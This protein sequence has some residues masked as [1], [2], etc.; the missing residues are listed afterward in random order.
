MYDFLHTSPLTLLILTMEGN[1]K[2]I[3]TI[4]MAIA[5]AIS[6]GTMG[7]PHAAI[8]AT[9][10]KNGDCKAISIPVT[11]SATDTEQLSVSATFCTPTVWQLSEKTIDIM[12]SGATY[13]QTYWDWPQDAT[14]YSYV[15]KTLGAGRGTLTFDRLGTGQ[16]SRMPGG[17]LAQTVTTDA[18]V[19]HQL[20]N[21]IHDQGYTHVNGVSHSL[22]SIVLTKEAALYNDLDK[23]V[24]TGI[25][26]L[27][28]IGLNAPNFATSLY[29]AP[30]D[31][32]FADKGYDTTYLTSLPD[33]RGSVFYDPNTA[34]P[35]VIA[36]DEAHK[37]VSTAGELTSSI[38]ELETPAPLNSTQHIT[39][40]VLLVMGQ[41][42][43]IFCNTLV[44]CSSAEAVAASERPYYANSAQFKAITIPNTAHNLTLHP[45]ADTS[46]Q[47]INEW[48]Q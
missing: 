45:S 40:P 31:P 48:M 13:N 35:A 1:M 28:D 37:D 47:K 23:L 11:T 8:A 18:F 46:F 21:W 7:I 2:K 38:L 30:L 26:H 4:T 33:R 15:A 14:R 41:T 39:A 22:G 5:L 24:V 32:A 3:I 42:D 25:L 16:S 12:V 10:N 9:A 29:P 27:P 44:D 43:N 17:G 6:I 36:Y 34:D 20:V 19:L